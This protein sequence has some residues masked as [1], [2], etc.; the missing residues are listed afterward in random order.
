[1]VLPLRKAETTYLSLHISNQFSTFIILQYAFNHFYP[2]IS[3]LQSG[4]TIQEY[5]TVLVH[6]KYHLKSAGQ[7]SLS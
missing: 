4:I 2:Q 5:P 6:I 3:H 1:M 7:S